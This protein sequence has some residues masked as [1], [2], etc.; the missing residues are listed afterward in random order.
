MFENLVDY[1]MREHGAS[2]ALVEPYISTDW[3]DEYQTTY[4]RRFR[5]YPRLARRIHFFSRGTGTRRHAESAV[6]LLQSSTLAR[7]YKGYCVVRPFSPATIVDAVVAGPD[8]SRTN[9]TL[10]PCARSFRVHVAGRALEVSGTP[11]LE[12]DGNV[13]VCAEAALWVVAR[14]L[15]AQGSAVRYRPSDM[16]RLATKYSTWGSLREGLDV[17]QMVMAMTEMAANPEMPKFGEADDCLVRIYAR[18]LSGLPVIVT[19]DDHA[20]TIV[21]WSYGSATNGIVDSRL[22]ASHIQTLIGHDDA[23]SAYVRYSVV[24]DRRTGQGTLVLR[25]RDN[26][27]PVRRIIAPSFPRVALR[28]RDVMSLVRVLID[29]ERIRIFG[30]IWKSVDLK[31]WRYRPILLPTAEFMR[32]VKS[33]APPIYGIRRVLK[34]PR[35]VIDGYAASLWPKHIWVVEL[36]SSSELEKY[37]PLEARVSGELILDATASPTLGTDDPDGPAA[38]LSLYLAGQI[39][40][41]WTRTKPSGA[42]DTEIQAW[43]VDADATGRPLRPRGAVDF[44]LDDGHRP[45]KHTSLVRW[46]AGSLPGN[47]NGEGGTYGP[48]THDDARSG[49]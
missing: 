35:F 49:L 5:E 11:F 45:S 41:T 13:S 21:G 30:D 44:V 1:M 8:H 9:A 15:H 31:D 18:L 25:G 24:V 48:R 7:R 47:A 19:S 38:F 33:E 34:R 37:G 40:R 23:R 28:V 6:R 36:I 14:C 32:R 29:R 42:N 3:A 12:Q 27:L 46:R 2:L 4:A 22:T 16:G 39:F 10:I 43:G 17:R 20:V 26:D